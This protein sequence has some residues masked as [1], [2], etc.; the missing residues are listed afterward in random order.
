MTDDNSSSTPGTPDSPASP[1]GHAA[2]K[3]AGQATGQA[4][5]QA[6]QLAQQTPTRGAP[7]LLWLLA[8]LAVLGTGLL[9]FVFLQQRQA[10]ETLA[11]DAY[12][13]QQSNVAFE[14]RST[15][16]DQRLAE[17]EAARADLAQQLQSV[18]DASGDSAHQ[19]DVTVLR[20]QL[21]A[22]RQDLAA[23]AAN[24]SADQ[25]LVEA[26][27]LLRLAQQQA[28][29]GHN[30]DAA[31]SLY[32]NAATVLRQNNTPAVQPALVALQLELDALRAVQLP[33][34][35][36]IYLQLG[37]LLQQLATLTVQSEGETP[38]QFV[39]PDATALP[40]TASWWQRLKHTISQY[41][42]VTRRDVPVL[43]QLTPQ[44][45]ALVHQV[46]ALQFE[47]ARLAL[48]QGNAS[49]YQAAL[50]AA[51]QGITQQ[52]QGEGKPALL[53]SLQRL[54]ASAIVADIPPLGRALQ[55]L[56]LGAA[57]TATNGETLT[58][59]STASALDGETLP[60]E[61]EA[62]A[63]VSEAVTVEREAPATDSEAAT[64]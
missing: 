50:E 33:D 18:L 51:T 20:N 8:L 34:I 46:I 13:L 38:L 45:A 15:A 55:A 29:L 61:S 12:A 58:L 42:V 21:A 19:A 41:F 17:A 16:F 1:V 7:A 43:A 53:A 6:A 9:G 64:P 49:V 22:L 63:A 48:L 31:I 39:A 2:G 35:A 37:E 62:S 5:R 25:N 52:L 3:A 11:G 57:V 56:E 27:S 14:Q 59:E 10:M 26:K 47:T 23:Q 24:S 40:A 36:G 28:A 32:M 30:I 54:Q 4:A 44:Q 60:M